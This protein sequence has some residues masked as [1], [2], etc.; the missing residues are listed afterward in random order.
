MRRLVLFL[1]LRKRAG[2]S[3]E[4]NRK[5][6]NERNGSEKKRRERENGREKRKK[7]GGWNNIFLT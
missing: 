5:I 3:M 6:W 7:K 1:S 2:Y 4:G